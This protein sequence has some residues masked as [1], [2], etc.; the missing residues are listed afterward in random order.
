MSEVHCDAAV[1]FGATGDLAYK[2]IFPAAPGHGPPRPSECA[3]DRRG[4]GRVAPRTSSS[5]RGATA[6]RSTAASTRRRSPSC[7]RSVRYVDGDYKDPAT[8]TALPGTFGSAQ[9]P[10]HYLAIP[11]AALFAR[12]R[13]GATRQVGVRPRRSRHRRKAVRHGPRLGTGPQPYPAGQLRRGVDLPDRP[14]P[15]EEPVQNLLHF[16]FANA[17]LEPLWNRQFVESVQVTEMAETFGVQGRSAFYEGA[18]TIRDVIQNH[19][20]QVV[21]NLAMELPV[22]TDSESVRN[23]KVKV[24]K[25]MKTLDAGSSAGQ[26]AATA[27]RR[28]SRPV[29]RWRPTPRCGW[30]STRK[31]WQGGAGSLP[32][33]R[34]VPPRHLHGG[35]RP[36][37][38]RPPL[39]YGGSPPPNHPR[40][41][42]ARISPLGLGFRPR[43]WAG[44]T[45]RAALVELRV[46]RHDEPRSMDAYEPP[47]HRG[48]DSDATDFAARTTGRRRGGSWSRFSGDVTLE[49]VRD[50]G[51]LGPREAGHG[52][53]APGGRQDPAVQP[54]AVRA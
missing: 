13:R 17:I 2:K 20:F 45:S 41:A 52:S 34:E 31:R 12:R 29:Q 15:R 49:P 28:G 3:S 10:A 36:G 21:A 24:L 9:H 33:G 35:D 11:P 37:F 51:T 50:P 44:R 18:G 8:F 5:A 6:S 47:A 40:R 16:R 46:R 43:T 30:R 27:M 32:P 54:G 48:D 4:P 39:V 14:L 25:A 22:S 7:P 26:F 38:R 23:E 53:C 19:L 42:S 1:F